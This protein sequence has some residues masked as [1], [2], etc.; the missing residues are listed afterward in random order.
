MSKGVE[1]T[2]PLGRTYSRGFEELSKSLV[3]FHSV[4]SEGF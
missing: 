3:G 4:T 1:T 2:F